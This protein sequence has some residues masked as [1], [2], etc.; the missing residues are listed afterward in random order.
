M[1]CKYD[2]ER[3]R[4]TNNVKIWVKPLK[5]MNRIRREEIYAKI[6]LPK[7]IGGEI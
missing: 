1:V 7:H 2:R 6:K 4:E 5:K 3:E